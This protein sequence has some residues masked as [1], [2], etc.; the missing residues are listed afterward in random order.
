M[1]TDA[2]GYSDRNTDIFSIAFLDVITNTT[3]GLIFVVIL[4]VGAMAFRKEAGGMTP[5]VMQ[6]KAAQARTTGLWVGDIGVEVPLD[7]LKGDGGHFRD[8]L[9]S[10]DPKT[11]RVGFQVDLGG[12]DSYQEAT[13]ICKEVGVDWVRVDEGSLQE[14]T[15]SCKG[16]NV[17]IEDTK[18][19]CAGTSL[20]SPGG[21]FHQWLQGL[22]ADKHY[23]LIVVYPDGHQ[24]FHA[25]EKELTLAGFETRVS[26]Q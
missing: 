21:T 5:S 12:G 9:K 24:A 19:A 23:V 1:E 6:V 13:R 22:R 26:I 4:L 2:Y 18:E 15:V 7:E 10:L 8:W 16:E 11:T 25:V 17:I 3:C 20:T 14:K